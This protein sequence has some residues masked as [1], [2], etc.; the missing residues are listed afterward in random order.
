MRK[1]VILTIFVV[2]IVAIVTVGFYGAKMRVYDEIKHVESIVCTLVADDVNNVSTKDSKDADY[3]KLYEA[4]GSGHCDYVINRVFK[5][6]LRV[7]VTF[8]V[9][10]GD[11]TDKTL[12]YIYD[13]NPTYYEFTDNEDGS[14]QFVFHAPVTVRLRVKPTDKAASNV[15]FV[16]LL[17]I[18]EDI[19]G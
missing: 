9:R 1:S 2:Y 11:A 3:K 19:L 5:E 18:Q 17:Q 7:P 10:P 16:V 13:E 4:T 14:V 8:E 12:E 15:E 6:G